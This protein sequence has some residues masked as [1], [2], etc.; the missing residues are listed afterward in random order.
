MPKPKIGIM[1]IEVKRENDTVD[2][3]FVA[4]SGEHGP[5]FDMPVSLAKK[6]YVKLGEVLNEAGHR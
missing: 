6:L 1:D 3:W 4:I 5:K 2:I